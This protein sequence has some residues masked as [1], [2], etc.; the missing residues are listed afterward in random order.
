[1]R[2]GRRECRALRVKPDVV[3]KERPGSRRSHEPELRARRGVRRDVLGIGPAGRTVRRVDRVKRGPTLAAVAGDLH[4]HRAAADRGPVIGELQ[5]RPDARGAC[6]G[7]ADQ[8][9]RSRDGHVRPGR[10][11]DLKL[12]VR[13]VR[14]DLDLA[15]GRGG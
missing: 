7:V 14:D 13:G 8:V 1:M 3:D 5:L 15:A 9:H 2:I 11:L 6:P 10:V 4:L 12:E